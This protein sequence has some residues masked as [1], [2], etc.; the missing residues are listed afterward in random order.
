MNLT[1]QPIVY[2]QEQ[3]FIL[4][5]WVAPMRRQYIN[6]IYKVKYVKKGNSYQSEILKQPAERTKLS[7]TLK[8][9]NDTFILPVTFGPECMSCKQK[10]M[11]PR[12][13]GRIYFPTKTYYGEPC[14]LG[15]YGTVDFSDAASKGRA[16]IIDSSLRIA[17]S[18][19]NL[20][21]IS[22]VLTST[23]SEKWEEYMCMDEALRSVPFVKA[24]GRIYKM[25]QDYVRTN[26]MHRKALLQNTEVMDPN[27]VLVMENLYGGPLAELPRALFYIDSIPIDHFTEEWYYANIDFATSI[28]RRIRKDDTIATN[29][30]YYES[31][32]SH[33][34]AKIVAFAFTLFVSQMSYKPDGFNYLVG[35]D[36]AAL[37]QFEWFSRNA[38][39][40]LS[41]DCEDFAILLLRMCRNLQQIKADIPMVLQ[42]KSAMRQY[43]PCNALVKAHAASLKFNTLETKTPQ[44]QQGLHRLSL[45]E[46]AIETFHYTIFHMTCV[47]VPV[48]QFRMMLK[49][50]STVINDVDVDDATPKNTLFIEGTVCLY[51][52]MFEESVY[53]A[54]D[55]IQLSKLAQTD[56]ESS[57]LLVT[58]SFRNIKSENGHVLPSMY[59]NVIQ[60]CTDAL[61]NQINYDNRDHLFST[62]LNV[63]AKN[64]EGQLFLGPIAQEYFGKAEDMANII[65][66]PDLDIRSIVPRYFSAQDDDSEVL[67]RRH[68]NHWTMD[69]ELMNP[70][71]HVDLDTYHSQKNN[72]LL[73]KMMPSKCKSYRADSSS[74]LAYLPFN[75]SVPYAE[76]K[77]YFKED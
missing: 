46:E 69:S 21:D 10:N 18:D 5:L 43:V 33:E 39:R 38:V 48:D 22:F 55:L 36:E 57:N 30:I 41:G 50:D 7:F 65:L 66:Q 51:P 34:R 64:D 24:T 61:I 29:D 74:D 28:M 58:P 1:R 71:M 16:E 17:Q 76:S 40:L 13:M 35:D 49:S 14:S 47:L 31:L 63:T 67:L 32:S 68:M 3:Y 20:G 73:M 8:I 77:I 45:K 53:S 70:T 75:L 72:E 6:E 4:Y 52:D 59:G 54:D 27:M 19:A 9:N 12:V 2:E 60:L 15:E 11:K 25:N 44:L 26:K 42:A 62:I 23:P 37:Q 56:F